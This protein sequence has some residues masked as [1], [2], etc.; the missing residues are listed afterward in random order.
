VPQMSSKKCGT[1]VKKHASTSKLSPSRRRIIN[2][3]HVEADYG[4]VGKSERGTMALECL[5]TFPVSL[6]TKDND[7]MAVLTLM[8]CMNSVAISQDMS[9]YSLCGML[10]GTYSYL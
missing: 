7:K 6:V 3:L 9:K 8:S 10:I 4:R 2:T 1:C 5:E